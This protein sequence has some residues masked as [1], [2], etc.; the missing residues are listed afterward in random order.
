MCDQHCWHDFIIKDATVKKSRT[1]CNRYGQNQHCQFT[2]C[3]QNVLLWHGHTLDVF[4]TTG[5]SL[6]KNRLF[7][8]APDI[9]EPSFQFIHTE[10]CLW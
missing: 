5:Q 4:L 10:I 8:T 2:G 1:K 9:D 3:T 6:V 7:K